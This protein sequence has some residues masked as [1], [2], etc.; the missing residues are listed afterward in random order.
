M[1]ISVEVNIPSL[2]PIGSFDMKTRSRPLPPRPATPLKTGFRK[3][4]LRPGIN[5]FFSRFSKKRNCTLP[6]IPMG[7]SLLPV[8]VSLCCRSALIVA[9]RLPHEQLKIKRFLSFFFNRF[10]ILGAL[11]GG[12]GGGMSAASRRPFSRLSCRCLGGRVINGR[13]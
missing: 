2:N 3:L 6:V 13:A 9:A 10:L 8:A 5:P 4:S 12:R 11:E 1:D 7:F